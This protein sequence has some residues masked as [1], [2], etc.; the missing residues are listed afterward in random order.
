MINSFYLRPLC[1]VGVLMVL[2]MLSVVA[3]AKASER[4]GF[5]LRYWCELQSKDY[6]LSQNLTPYNWS[7]SGVVAGEARLVRGR[8]KI[9]NE[10]QNVNCRVL[11]GAP[12]RFAVIQI[13]SQPFTQPVH[14]SEHVINTK[15]QLHR[16]CKYKSAQLFLQQSEAALYNWVILPTI[17]S[18][19]LTIRGRWTVDKVNRTVQ[20]SIV[21]G[22][23]EKYANIV[24]E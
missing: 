18:D 6:F 12:K 16:W 24:L 22:S 4:H 5:N 11:K 2:S 3:Q 20:C 14:E 21:K 19:K 23:A 8:W 7:A 17:K 15:K 10:V 1:R 9:A 13:P